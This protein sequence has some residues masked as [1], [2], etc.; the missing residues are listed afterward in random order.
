MTSMLKVTVP[1]P[2][3]SAV[4]V[5]MSVTG[6]HVATSTSVLPAAS[7]SMSTSLAVATR[8]IPPSITVSDVSS[9][10][11]SELSR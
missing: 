4:S 3:K 5:H 11:S 9:G 6:S 10:S 2:S 7:V 1:T 8:R